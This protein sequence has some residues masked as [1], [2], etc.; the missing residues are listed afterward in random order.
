MRLLAV[1]ELVTEDWLYLQFPLTNEPIHV[2]QDS[3]SV[4][5]VVASEVALEVAV[6]RII[7]L[8]ADRVPLELFAQLELV[9]VAAVAANSS[10][11]LA[12]SPVLVSSAIVVDKQCLSV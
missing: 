7:E 12:P 11:A 3:E 4:P 9:V 6:Q 10:S 2:A 1:V 8:A 5:V